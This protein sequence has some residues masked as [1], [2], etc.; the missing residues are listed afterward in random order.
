MT[1]SDRIEFNE[2]FND[3]TNSNIPASFPSISTSKNTLWVTPS[4]SSSTGFSCRTFDG[5]GRKGVRREFSVFGNKGMKMRQ[6]EDR[7]IMDSHRVVLSSDDLGGRR[8]VTSVLYQSKLKECYSCAQN[9]NPQKT[10]R[11]QSSTGFDG[12]F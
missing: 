4:K 9:E 11:N 8:R 6:A 3:L 12:H 10:R 7:F 5:G 2:N 1:S